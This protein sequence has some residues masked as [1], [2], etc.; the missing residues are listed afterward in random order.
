[1]PEYQITHIFK[2][3]GSDSQVDHITHVW[4]ANYQYYDDQKQIRQGAWFT[5]EQ[6]IAYLKSSNTFYYTHPANSAKAY[7]DYQRSAS[8]REYIKTRADGTT[9]DNLLSLP[10]E[11][12][13]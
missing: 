6:V 2:P 13:R 1:M 4:V 9:R 11:A 5:V 10:N 8:G 7:I 12:V 3:G